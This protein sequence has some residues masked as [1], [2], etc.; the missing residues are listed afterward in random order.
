MI[1]G[2]L[3]TAYQFINCQLLKYGGSKFK[4]LKQV[5]GNKLELLGD[6]DPAGTLMYAKHSSNLGVRYSFYGKRLL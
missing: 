5:S 1:G 6:L 2:S 3:L 4:L